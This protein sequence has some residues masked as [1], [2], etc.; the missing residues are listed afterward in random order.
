MRYLQTA[1]ALCVGVAVAVLAVALAGPQAQAS[2]PPSP[3]PPT[4]GQPTISG[5]QGVGFEQ[6]LR[7]DPTNANRLYTSVPGALS[8]D[9]S[10]IW[11]STDAGKTFKWVVAGI[12]KTGKVTPCA[13]GGDTEL[14]VDSGANLYFID[15]TLLNFSTARSGDFGATFPG[16]SNS[17]VPDTLVDRQWYAVDGNPAT[18]DGTGTGA[19]HNIYLVND[20]IGP[21]APMCQVSGIGNNVLAMYRSPIPGGGALAGIQFGPAKEVSAPLT[22]DEGIMGN[23]EVSPIAT[24]IDEAPNTPAVKHVYVIHDDATFSRILIGRCYPVPFSVG[25]PSGLRCRDLPVATLGSAGLNCPTAKT[26]GNFPT[27]AIDSA[28]NLYAVWEQ[29]PQDP[30]NCNITG[31]TVLKYSYSTDQG[32]NWATPKTI[33]PPGLHN[34]VFA[35]VAAGDN[36]R[37][38]VAWYGTPETAH[39]SDPDCGTTGGPD[40]TTNGIWS[41]Y[42]TQTLNG[43]AANPT[44]TAPILAGE[45][46][47]H[48]GT[49]QTVIGHQCGDRTLGDFM[50][51]R[52]GS[53]GE[54]QIAYADSNND[55][56]PFAPHGMYVRQNGGSSVSA[57][58]PQVSGDPIL[59]NAASDPAGDGRRETNSVS[60][61]NDP[62]LD[63]L[64]SSI[65]QPDLSACHPTGT[66]CYRVRMTVN[67]LTLAPPGPDAFAV[68]LTQW[69]VPASPG[70]TSS[71]D[72][73]KNGGK[74]PF[75]YFESNGT[76]WSGQNAALLLGGGVTLTYP[77][78][79]QITAPGACTRT[80]GPLG[81]ITIDVPIADVS[82]ES[83]VAPLSSRLYSVTASTM[84]LVEPAETN[85]PTLQPFQLFTG[86]IGG[87]LFDLIDVVRAYDFVPGA[88]GGGGGGGGGCHE[89]DGD[90]HIQGEQS[91]QASFHVDVDDC[92]DHD[93]EHVDFNDPGSNEDFHSTEILSV[94]FDDVEH[95]MTIV[96]EGTVNGVPVTFTAV[97]IDNI[98]P[99]L[100]A[101]Q[102]T[103]SDGY[104]NTGTLLDGTITLQ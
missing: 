83:G 67:N 78:T 12:P 15:L 91:G 102:I 89:G 51:L 52:I 74:N 55:D 104:T 101:F 100:D 82:L 16:C 103:V 5:I 92:E 41:L 48:K 99:A 57:S 10:W 8:S 26:G 50:Q 6:D 65:S 21:G 88:G 19:G 64:H 80:L 38:D 98:S 79:T 11:H 33:S 39:A 28:G 1:S 59:I 53:R 94:G 34:N 96:G 17:G 85:R 7:L 72:P 31:D 66:P 24:T 93:G 37:V 77:G 2:P 56:E 45:H 73:C 62:N 47:V 87:D 90:G 58:T 97:E 84:T 42:L 18:G 95:T 61:P 68:W 44:F 3:G 27:M 43:H 49:I 40:A 60:L 70:C 63:I 23:D 76:C 29:A 30:V 32:N 69:L 36:G 86:P 25:D 35:W 14:A 75:V 4:F 13:G 46:Y 71:A 20:E 54:A 22:C 81:T 9:T